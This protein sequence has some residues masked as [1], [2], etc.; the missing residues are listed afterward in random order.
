MLAVLFG[1]LS[2][3][4]PAAVSR[5]SALSVLYLLV[6][7]SLIAYAAYVWL[8]HNTTPAR[9]SSYAFVN[10]LVAMLLG[11]WLGDESFGIL[12]IAAA[13]LVIASVAL[14]TLE[15]SPSASA[16]EPIDCG[17]RQSA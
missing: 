17:G 14:I 6:F 1:D 12:A 16:E 8:L 10:P 9:V 7:G 5:E 3:F 4:D 15:V 13:V 2:A 11:V